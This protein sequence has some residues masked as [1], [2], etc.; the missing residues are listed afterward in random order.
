MQSYPTS[1]LNTSKVRSGASTQ[2]RAKYDHDTVKVAVRV[3]PFSH[4]EMQENTP[5]IVAMSNNVTKIVDPSLLE[6]GGDIN[7]M[8]NGSDSAESQNFVRSFA[9]DHSYW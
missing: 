1:S 5:L 7:D 2:N 9:F 4:R 8:V 3:R 6:Y